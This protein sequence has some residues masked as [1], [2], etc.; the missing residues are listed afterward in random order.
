[1]DDTVIGFNK[2]LEIYQVEKIIGYVQGTHYIAKNPPKGR[3]KDKDKE[4]KPCLE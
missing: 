2:H 3:K 4:V 1:M